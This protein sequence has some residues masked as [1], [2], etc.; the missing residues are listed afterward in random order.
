MTTDPNTGRLLAN[1]YQLVELI[2]QGAMGRVYQ[3]K[4]M[5][6]G[7]VIVAIK[8][9]S[10]TLLNERMRDRF[11][12]EATISALLGEKSLHIVKVRDYGVDE[13]DV[14][15]YVMEYLQ[16]QSLS[17][18]IRQQPLSLVRFLKVSCQISSGLQHAH[19]GIVF[20]GK[21]SSI[22]HR[23][24]KPSNILL[25]QDS[26]LGE[27]VK[28]LDFGVAKLLQSDSDQTHS[29]M[30]TLAYCSPEQMEGKEL[31]KRSDIYSLGVM[32]FEML[33]GEMP[34]LG[35]TRSFGGWYK[36]HHELPPRSFE[37]VKPE[38]KLPKALKNLV[39][40]C[41]A[42]QPEDRPESVVEILRTL[43][44]IEDSLKPG[45]ELG[46]KIGEVLK[47]SP[48]SSEPLQSREPSADEI[49]RRTSWPK[50]KPQKSI[51][52]PHIMRRSEEFLATLWVML[53]KQD[54][55]NRQVSTRYN[56]FLCVMSP[57]PMVLWITALH[58]REHGARW[59]P[60]Y[61]DLKTVLGQ[62]MV[63]LL[64]EAGYYRLLFFAL[65]EPEHCNTVMTSTIASVQ[66]QRLR[67]WATTSSA[68]LSAAQPHM[69]RRILKQ[70]YEKLKPKI[71]MKLEAVNTDYPTD[72]S[73]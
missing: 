53:A 64:G 57:H 67:E 6:L 24:I 47:K 3:A 13:N 62:K 65:S 46:H 21:L 2:G 18:V 30:G 26:S 12:R 68:L 9:L 41:L 38:R 27:L 25:I 52:F 73:E 48:I 33:T 59:L 44:S 5:L 60:C 54:I 22:I 39:I 43:R 63:R 58:N 34:I 42:K 16:G 10:Q 56:Q 40:N 20:Q 4:D 32:M 17:Q 55:Q 15:F 31:D 37:S 70:E 36:A 50:D 23:D 72:I 45:M 14:P 7:G 61:L 69:S 51:V 1:R 71:L 8:F 29:F 49:C 35:E 11:E 28:I 66:R 19:Q